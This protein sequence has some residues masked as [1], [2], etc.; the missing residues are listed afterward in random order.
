M[1]SAGWKRLL[2]VDAGW[3]GMAGALAL[4]SGTF[5]DQIFRRVPLGF[6]YQTP[7]QRILETPTVA[8]AISV[9]GLEEAETLI[10]SPNVAVLDARP[11]VFFEMGHLPGA[12]SLSREQFEKDLAAL[13]VSVEVTGKTLVVYCS[14]ASCDDSAFVARALQ[15]RGLGP[16]RLFHGG[17]AAWE[18]AGKPVE[19]SP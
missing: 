1:E 11:R 16:L 9:I 6:R 15:Q 19:T 8:D 13:E 7:A 12:R 3:F 10:A 17:F 18:A 14:D 5:G 2:V 4:L